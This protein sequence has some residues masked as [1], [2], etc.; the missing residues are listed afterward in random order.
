MCTSTYAF[1]ILPD[2]TSV[3]AK[4]QSLSKK[5]KMN[6]EGKNIPTEGS[7][8]QTDDKKE[9]PGAHTERTS[10]VAYVDHTETD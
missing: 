4:W 1:Q 3:I 10:Y 7:V 5:E 9:N 6:D 2:I 8:T